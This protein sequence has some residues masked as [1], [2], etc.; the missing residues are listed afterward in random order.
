MKVTHTRQDPFPWGKRV[1]VEGNLTLKKAHNSTAAKSGYIKIADKGFDVYLQKRANG[2]KEDAR[3]RMDG[4]R[5]T[6]QE[7]AELEE[8]FSMNGHPHW[9]ASPRSKIKWQGDVSD[10]RVRGYLI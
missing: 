7:S 5:K 2:L 4:A 6:A 8:R 9:K 3:K 1:T 10:C